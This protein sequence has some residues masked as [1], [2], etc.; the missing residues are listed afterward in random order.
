M[1]G[2]SACLA[3]WV[4]QQI[5]EDVPVEVWAPRLRAAVDAAM[6]RMADLSEWW[7]PNQV[8]IRPDS[9]SLVYRRGDSV[10]A[11]TCKE[12]ESRIRV[13]WTRDANHKLPPAAWLKKMATILLHPV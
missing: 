12:T 5:R 13:T 9:V 10:A 7:E 8:S 1:K 3:T 2:K 11:L 6:F 4:L